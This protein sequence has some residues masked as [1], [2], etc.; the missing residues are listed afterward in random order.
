LLY[1]QTV[2]D[3]P[4]LPRTDIF[5]YNF[6]LQPLAELAPDFRHPLT[7]RSLLEHSRKL[8]HESHPLTVVEIDFD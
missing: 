2:S 8:D 4:P 7:G 5:D 6:V 1:G 3:T